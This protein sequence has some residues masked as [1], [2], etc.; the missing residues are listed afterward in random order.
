[1]I[2]IQHSVVIERPPEEVFGFLTE[3]ANFPKWQAGVLETASAGRLQLGDTFTE[4]RTFVGQRAESMLE[5]AEYIP[6][7][8]FFLRVVSGPWLFEVLHRL[9]PTDTGTRVEV[10]FQGE[11]KGKLRLA[12]PML[13]RAVHGDLEGNLS[14]LKDALEAGS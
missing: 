5:V 10:T 9:V 7:E 3:P 11:T 4:I 8:R 13:E 14:A 6:N 12:R 1:V 2:R